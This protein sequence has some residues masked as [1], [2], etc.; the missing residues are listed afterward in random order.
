MFPSTTKKPEAHS[1]DPHGCAPGPDIHGVHPTTKDFWYWHVMGILSPVQWL[2]PTT[3]DD[4]VWAAFRSRSEVF[5]TTHDA[6]VLSPISWLAKIWNGEL[7][8]A[9]DHSNW[10]VSEIS[11]TQR[12]YIGLSENIK[13]ES[14]FPRSKH[15]APQRLRPVFILDHIRTLTS[16]VWRPRLNGGQEGFQESFPVSWQKT[17]FVECW[18]M[19]FRHSFP[20]TSR[21]PSQLT[22]FNFQHLLAMWALQ[23]EPPQWLKRQ[24]TRTQTRH[25]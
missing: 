13:T 7:R 15:L 17:L 3:K 6:W 12:I 9:A 10:L 11:T 18:R 4:N 14:V 24:A 16:D 23:L 25:M 8:W 21:D 20:S 2:Y 19:L 22:T 5:G 1:L